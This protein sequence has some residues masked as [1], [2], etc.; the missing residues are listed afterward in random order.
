MS[1]TNPI[2][3][4]FGGM[5]KL[6]PGDD[7]ATLHVL[8]TLPRSP[9]GVIVDAGCGTGRQTLVLAGQ[10]EGVI[11][12]VDAHGA[13]LETLK[14]RAERAGLANRI[15]TH[16]MDMRDIPARFP[17]IDLLWSEGA[18]YNMGF[19]QALP[20]W[21]AAI[22]PGGHAVVSEL[23]WLRPDPPGDVRAFFQTGYP[24]MA[25]VARNAA[26][27][28]KAGYD[29]LGTHVLPSD[30]WVQGYYDVLEPRAQ[31]LLNHAEDAVRDVARETL[32]EIDVFRISEGS[33]GYVFYVLQRR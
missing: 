10:L 16:L 5:E 7:A 32:Q 19:A 29:V 25:S 27:A 24:D 3:L 9:Q 1:S 2:D 22:V 13:F 8:R 33:Y 28:E 4:L 14:R 23:S 26:D 21:A 17:R 11:Q 15:E 18:A 31:A 6:G 30:A 20:S 12:A